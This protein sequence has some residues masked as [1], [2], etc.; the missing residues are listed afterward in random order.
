MAK[1]IKR[2][3]L[4]ILVLLV[5]AIIA[6][7]IFAPAINERLR[8]KVAD[9]APFPITDQAQTLHESLTIGDWHADSLLWKRN[10]LKR[11]TRGQ[12]DIPRL[13]EGNVAIQVF[14]A[15]TKSPAGQNYNQNS[16]EAR[17]NITLLA[18][19][20]LWP[21]RTWNSI[22]ERAVYQAEKLH[23]FERKAPDDLKIIKT[24]SDLE[25]VLK[26]R[27][28]GED[29]VGGILG[30]EGA[31][32]LERDIANLPRLVDAGYRL[33]A[34]QHFFDNALGGSLHGFGNNG[35]TEFGRDV[36]R[37]VEE[38]NLIL[39]IAHSSPQVAADVLKMTD[40]PVVVSHTGIYSHCKAKRNYPDSLMKRIAASGGVIAIG[41]WADVTCDHTP[42]GVAATIKAAIKLLGEDSVS[43]GS[44]FD[45]SVTT[46]FDASEM[47]ALTQALIDAGLTD[48]QIA[49]VMGQNMLRVLRARLK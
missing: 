23:N 35:L 15:V 31:H 17:D 3:V 32:P 38:N 43:L 18:M 13:Q 12:V 47:S 4:G 45:G 30:I 41:F 1:F 36:V 21:I 49:K 7:L 10:L 44:D 40:M 6:F 33:V 46:G 24:R 8:N 29:I 37:Y 14:T 2:V 19:G 16:A 11:S 9:H 28:D 22:F 26:R 25:T 34:L 39:D 27:A 5:T 42:A 20:Q 48:D